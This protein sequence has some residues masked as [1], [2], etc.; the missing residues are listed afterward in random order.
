M[1]DL[2]VRDLALN[3]RGGPWAKVPD[4]TR[5]GACLG[6]LP[7]DV[8]SACST[9]GTGSPPPAPPPPTPPALA[10]FIANAQSGD[11]LDLGAVY[12]RTPGEP[13]APKL[14]WWQR[15]ARWPNG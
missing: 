5:C 9:C 12:R 6:A 13:D 3:C 2:P 1:A 7:P 10:D 4:I 14:T 8:R 11:V 15:F